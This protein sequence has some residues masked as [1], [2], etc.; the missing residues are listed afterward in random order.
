MTL[1]LMM[2][3]VMF[4]M[5]AHYL[6]SY[7]PAST[8]TIAAY[9]DEHHHPV[10]DIRYVNVLI[11]LWSA[12]LCYMISVTRGVRDLEQYYCGLPFRHRLQ[13]FPLTA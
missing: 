3:L 1:A 9:E 11:L 6:S 13:F 12:L 2:S 4:P 7:H 8:L 10:W 5:L